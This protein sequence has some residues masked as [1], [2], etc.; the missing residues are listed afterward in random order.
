MKMSG[1]TMKLEQVLTMKIVD[2]LW[3]AILSPGLGTRLSLE[4]E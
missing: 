1:L 3:N 4:Q 2:N